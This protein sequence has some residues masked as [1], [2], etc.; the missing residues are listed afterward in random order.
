MQSAGRPKSVKPGIYLVV[1]GLFA[2]VVLAGGHF[3]YIS[4]EQNYLR[5][6]ENQLAAV[7]RLKV[8][9]LVQ[10]RR[11]RIGDAALYAN[12]FF[13]DLVRRRVLQKDMRAD[14]LLTTWLQRVL[15][16][17]TYSRACVHD[18]SGKAILSI[19]Q[20]GHGF[21]ENVDSTFVE[22]CTKPSIQ[23]FY[24]DKSDGRGYLSLLMPVAESFKNK[25]TIAFAVLQIDPSYYLYPLLSAWPTSSRT[26]EI[27]L[28]RR[29]QNDVL[30]L[31]EPRFAANQALRLRNP[32]S[33]E[34]FSAIISTPPIDA[35]IRAVDYRGNSVL[36]HLQQVPD[37][38]WILAV[39]MDADEVYGP[40][41][42]RL[43][44]IFVL[45]AALLIGTASAI[46]LVWT[47]Q[48]A[49]F[50]RLRAEDAEALAASEARFRALFEHSPVAVF[51]IVSERIAMVNAA[52]I[53]LFK[54]ASAD[55]LLTKKVVDLIHPDFQQ[56]FFEKLSA[57]PTAPAAPASFEAAVVA[58]DG[59]IVSV[60]A[61]IVPFML[62]SVQALQVVLT[63]IRERKQREEEIRRLNEKLEQRVR[64][65]TAQLEAANREL[66]AFS[67][68]VSHDLRAPLHHI[69]GFADLLMSRCADQLSEKGQH[70]LRSIVEAVH[71]MGKLIDKLLHFSRTSRAE[72]YVKQVDMI[73][74]VDSAIEL[75]KPEFDQRIV[76]WRI[77]RL[78]SVM[79]DEVLLK[80]VWINLIHNA[81]KFTRTREKA[82]VE[83]GS[84][85]D[86]GEYVFYVKDNG[87]GFDMKYAQKLFGVFQ[88]LHSSKQFEGTGIGLANVQR[89]VARHGGRVWAHAEVNVGASFYFTL[90]LES[91][92][93]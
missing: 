27:L 72:M 67:Y 65:R 77:S 16:V 19:P 40:V 61:L 74:L 26:A 63:D 23:D 69:S 52:C 81:L 9:E 43:N 75:L 37:S 38:P 84:S 93:K 64:E 31:N 7:A 11:E 56:L 46:P 70:Y 55:Q 91:E 85:E 76:E 60:E 14:T 49:R 34:E 80:Q 58:L 57:L 88:R 50:D 89:I 59:T 62:G 1:F 10:W 79:G 39:K 51:I 25:R 22:G 29:D 82:V 73:A 71:N 20:P 42:E 32:L 30:L 45:A 6:V 28:F 35:T 13:C 2:A 4:Y 17:G 86:N 21:L 18:I 5:E 33:G 53:R 90:P 68:S 92:E 87:V 8:H 12:D 41:R 15:S 83:I 36:V 78:P 47:H 66:E 54:A 3:T 24:V 44:A 48:R